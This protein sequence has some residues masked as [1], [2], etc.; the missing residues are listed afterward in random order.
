[1]FY[2]SLFFITS[3]CLLPLFVASSLSY[4]CHAKYAFVLFLVF[5]VLFCFVKQEQNKKKE[6][7][8]RRRRQN[9]EKEGN[10]KIRT[11]QILFLCFPSFSIFKF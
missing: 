7:K 4:A 9:N 11:R 5:F 2:F 3:L 10:K 6:V 1:M 8:K